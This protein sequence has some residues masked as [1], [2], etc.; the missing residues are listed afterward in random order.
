MGSIAGANNTYLG[1]WH[2][3]S[4]VTE[5]YRE[6]TVTSHYSDGSS[7]TNPVTRGDAFNLFVT[8]NTQLIT[9]E[10]VTTSQDLSELGRG[11]GGALTVWNTKGTIS[12]VIVYPSDQSAARTNIEG[13]INNAYSI[14]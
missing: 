6:V 1:I 12:E 2:K 11:G 14:Y 5:T 3:G 8:D 7:A 10:G 4:T 9:F 13:N